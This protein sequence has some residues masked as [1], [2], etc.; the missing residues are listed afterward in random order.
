MRLVLIARSG[1]T[2]LQAMRHL[3]EDNHEWRRAQAC[4]HI[5]R[6]IA[7]TARCWIRRVEQLRTPTPRGG[8]RAGWQRLRPPAG[9]RADQWD[10]LETR[11][12][13]R[14]R[15][16]TWSWS[17]SRRLTIPRQILAAQQNKARGEAVG[18]MKADGVEYEERMERLQEATYPKPL[19]E[20]LWHAYDVYRTSYRG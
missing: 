16:W 5:R 10:L 2:R 8:L 4:R 11:P 3:L 20:L 14:N 15:A 12:L 9:L 17:S 7:M 1:A 13:L 18:Q 6:A 19:S